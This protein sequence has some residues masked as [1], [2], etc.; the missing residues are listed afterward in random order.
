MDPNQLVVGKM[1]AR[2]GF[3]HV[4]EGTYAGQAVAVSVI[5]GSTDVIMK[6]KR[7]SK[8][9]SRDLRAMSM[10]S[11]HPSVPKFHGYCSTMVKTD[12]NQ[13][14]LVNELC[15]YGDLSVFVETVEFQRLTTED[16]LLMCI[17]VLRVLSVMHE[18]RIYLQE[19]LQISRAACSSRY[20]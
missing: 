20:R 4:Y 3:K 12:E 7:S 1:I 2:G 19:G 11:N 6:S 16:R 17:D 18:E 9:L 15:N 8:L 10:L 5:N 13:I 14:V